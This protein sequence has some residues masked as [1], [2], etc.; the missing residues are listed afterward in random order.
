M[1][2]EILYKLPSAVLFVA[3]GQEKI[4]YANNAAMQLFSPIPL[5]RFRLQ[6]LLADDQQ[7]VK[8]DSFIATGDETGEFFFIATSNV[9]VQGAER[10]N[11]SIKVSVMRTTVADGIT[12][13]IRPFDEHSK[14]VGGP[15]QMAL[16]DPLT[17]LPNRELLR[18]RMEQ[19]IH[20]ASRLEKAFLGILFVDLDRF[21]KVNDTYGHAAGDAV[22]VEVAS[23]LRGCLRESDTVAR[24]GGDEFVVLICNLRDTEETAIV[25]ER[26]LDACSRPILIG[27]NIV[28]ISASIG[29][30]AWPT[31][32]LAVDELLHNADMAMYSSKDNGRNTLRFYD[33]QTN[34][35]AEV[36]ARVEAELKGRCVTV[37]LF[38]ITSHNFVR[39]P[40][41]SLVLRRL[42]GGATQHAG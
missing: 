21:K 15:W 41:E 16:Y 28:E 6:D 27:D 2:L 10:S 30:A 13:L 19:A 26:I 3:V 8:F 31:D 34:E 17:G 22:L 9:Q 23:R 40:G 14:A 5:A 1:Y 11:T 33:A 24:L 12:Y 42:F 18:D 20:S 39:A 29:V 4:T 7:R 35:K 38:C 36:R 37:I 25:A 32:G